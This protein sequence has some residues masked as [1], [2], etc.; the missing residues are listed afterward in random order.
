M[1][2]CFCLQMSSAHSL[3]PGSVCMGNECVRCEMS[4]QAQGP[5][6]VSMSRHMQMSVCKSGRHR[7]ILSPPSIPETIFNKT[8]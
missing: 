1:H 6:R 2:V 8:E 3:P 5:V 4:M 7:K